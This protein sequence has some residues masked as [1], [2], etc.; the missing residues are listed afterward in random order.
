MAPRGV[1]MPTMTSAR[2]RV[3]IR[4]W[5]SLICSATTRRLSFGKVHGLVIEFSSDLGPKML[6]ERDP[7]CRFRWT[8]FMTIT[9]R[10]LRV[11]GD[12]VITSN[13][14]PQEAVLARFRQESRQSLKNALVGRYGGQNLA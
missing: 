5:P 7:G 1:G 13:H 6:P 2:Q 8:T 4:Q 10:L 9:G 11:A 3:G 14:R 12:R